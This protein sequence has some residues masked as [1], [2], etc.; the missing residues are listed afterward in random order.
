[1][2][3]VLHTLFRVGVIAK[4]C[5]GVFEV[6]GGGLLFFLDPVRIHRAVRILTQH[7]LSEDPHDAVAHY[8]LNSSRHLAAG[9]V[10]FAALYL[11][12]HGL[13]KVALVIGLLLKHRSAY[14]LAIAAFLLFLAYQ[15]YRY[16]HTHAVALLVLS[17]VDGLVIGLTW[18]EYRRLLTVRAFR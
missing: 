11:L 2:R 14:P 18:L 15:M 7:E 5:D 12:W 16:T 4:G 13:V 6:I 17:V 10:T 8:L 9:A 1:M 3:R